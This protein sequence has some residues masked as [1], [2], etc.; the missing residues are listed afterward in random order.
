[1]SAAL[2]EIPLGQLV[3]F[4]INLF[5]RAVKVKSGESYFSATLINIM[6]G[7]NRT[8]WRASDLR[9]FN[10]LENLVERN[11]VIKDRPALSKTKMVL[12]AA[13]KK[14]AK[15]GLNK[16]RRKVIDYLCGFSVLRGFVGFCWLLW[17]LQAAALPTN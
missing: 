11:F 13:V 8:I 1:M 7:F 16:K 10:W 9:S 5:S 15:E 12:K 6:G 4:F 2:G 14:R 3:V 17:K